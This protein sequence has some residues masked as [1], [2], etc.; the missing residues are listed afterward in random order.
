[1]GAAEG[2]INEAQAGGRLGLTVEVERWPIRGGFTISRGS[3]HEAGGGGGPVSDRRDPGRG[4]SLP[5][6]RFWQTLRKPGSAGQAFRR[7]NCPRGKPAGPRP[8]SSRRRCPQRDRLRALGLRGEA[9]GK[10]RR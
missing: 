2:E 10:Q 8:I 1:M 9:V 6:P 4:E 5:L 3:K 7:P